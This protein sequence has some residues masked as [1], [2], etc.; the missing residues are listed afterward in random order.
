M[1]KIASIVTM[2][3]VFVSLTL[4]AFAQTQDDTSA[5]APAPTQAVTEAVPSLQDNANP[6]SKAQ[7][8]VLEEKIEALEMEESA[9]FNPDESNSEV[10]Q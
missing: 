9:N 5:A 2:L 10:Q 7:K 3:L 6:L 8:A 4:T 1:K